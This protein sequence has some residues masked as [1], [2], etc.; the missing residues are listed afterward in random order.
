MIG[1]LSC[2]QQPVLVKI[3]NTVIRSYANLAV[4]LCQNS[5]CD[6]LYWTNNDT[7]RLWIQIKPKVLQMVRLNTVTG[8]LV[9]DRQSPPF[10][11]VKNRQHN[12]PR[13]NLI[14]KQNASGSHISLDS[15]QGKNIKLFW[16]KRKN[17]R[18]RVYLSR[19]K[20][21]IKSA[22][23]IKKKVV[24]LIQKK[25]IIPSLNL[26][27]FGLWLDPGNKGLKYERLKAYISSLQINTFFDS[28]K[29]DF[30]DADRFSVC[31]KFH[32]EKSVRNLWKQKHFTRRFKK[33][34]L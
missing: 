5:W 34:C 24:K 29:N 21:D 1:N 14:T 18:T 22:G 11:R 28:L 33:T 32:L 3:D 15:S 7:V 20:S 4:N 10:H 13:D 2:W 25:K 30:S 26:I 31:Q 9:Y 12:A 6:E 27:K 16:E 17:G 23:A 8:A 19:D